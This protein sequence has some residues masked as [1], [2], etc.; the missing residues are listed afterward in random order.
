MVKNAS[1][2][3]FGEMKWAMVVK[4]PKDMHLS[5]SFYLKI[6]QNNYTLGIP[7]WSVS[8]HSNQLNLSAYQFYTSVPKVRYCCCCCG[9]RPCH[10]G[11]FSWGAQKKRKWKS[12][13]W[14]LRYGMQNTVPQ[15]HW[16]AEKMPN[17]KTQYP[18]NHWNAEKSPR[19]KTR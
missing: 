7:N 4:V 11:S 1:I 12:N 3:I 17:L 6:E 15:N 19:F 18:E 14:S 9:L 8:F 5:R 16:N 13:K 10:G 2:D